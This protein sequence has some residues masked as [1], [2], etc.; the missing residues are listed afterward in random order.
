MRQ[1]ILSM[2]D[3]I[4]AD[5]VAGA[6]EREG[7]AVQTAASPDEIGLYCRLTSPYALL[8][9]VTSHAPYTL[10]QRLEVRRRVAEQAPQCKVVLLV[11]ENSEPALARQ[12]RQ[13]KKDG[14]IDQFIYSSISAAYLT[15]LMD[16]L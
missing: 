10:P 1:V 6:L 14:L 9:E 3:F 13:A 2:K 15:A 7:F 11:D 8:M 12:V 4:F 5:A 16:T